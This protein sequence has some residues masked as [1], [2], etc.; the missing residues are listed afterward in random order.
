MTALRMRGQALTETAIFM[1]IA[2]LTLFAVIWAAQ[3]GVM[4][5]R[6][7]SAIRY[8]GVISNELN[9]YVEYSFYALYN[10][11]GSVSNNSPVPTQTCNAPTPDAL[12]NGGA[13]P[14]PT[15]GPFWTA[16]AA[17]VAA[18]CS[19]VNSQSA[20]FSSGMNQTAIVL[21]NSTS[22]Q[23]VSIV[24]GYL[25]AAMG[26]GKIFSMSTLNA[27]ASGN[28]I[29]PADMKTMMTCHPGL[30]GTVG[31]SLVVTPPPSSLPSPTPLSEPVPAPTALS[32]IC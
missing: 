18:S 26:F 17:P 21:S 15:S 24:P 10:S 12:Y 13:Y 25:Q 1:P 5:E 2:L 29:K 14:G 9:P 11:L 22:I 19:Q 20:S 16:T 3:Y 7:E 31:A 28:F 8:S 30:Q 32:E 23:A 6:V 4:S 27:S